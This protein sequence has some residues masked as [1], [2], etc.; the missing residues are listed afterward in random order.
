MLLLPTPLTCFTALLPP[1][2]FTR[3][4]RRS[5][6]WPLSEQITPLAEYHLCW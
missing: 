6:L 3:K 5:T 2:W 1:L 4:P